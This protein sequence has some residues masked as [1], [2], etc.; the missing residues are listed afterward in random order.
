MNDPLGRLPGLI[1][2]LGKDPGELALVAVWIE[3]T[4]FAP[5][6]LDQMPT[7]IS[8]DRPHHLAHGSL[9]GRLLEGLDHR[10]SGEPS[11]V[12]TLVLIGVVLEELSRQG[13][14]DDSNKRSEEHT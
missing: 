1:Q 5:Q 2:P 10:A 13:F 8:L 4:G 9:E 11:Q 12:A 6:D 3:G 14:Q 7:E